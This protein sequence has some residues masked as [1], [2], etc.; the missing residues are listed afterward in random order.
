MYKSQRAPTKNTISS[1]IA[2][3]QEKNE[4]YNGVTLNKPICLNDVSID[5]LL[6]Y[7]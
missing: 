5:L 4:T 2:W 3:N 1:T 6:I 7:C